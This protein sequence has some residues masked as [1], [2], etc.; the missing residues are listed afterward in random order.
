M[1]VRAQEAL[2]D[3]LIASARIFT[4]TLLSQAG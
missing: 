2:P 3:T 1:C 4:E